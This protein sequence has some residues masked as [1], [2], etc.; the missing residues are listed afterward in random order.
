M[1][2]LSDI[3][4]LLTDNGLVDGVSDYTLRLGMMPTDPDRV[5]ALYEYPG[6][7]PEPTPSTVPQSPNNPAPTDPTT[8]VTYPTLQVRVRSPKGEYAEARAKVE[9]I[10]RY[11]HARLGV[12]VGTRSY[13]HILAQSDP[14]PLG[15]DDVGRPELTQNFT[16]VIQETI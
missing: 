15:Q 3:G 5:V 10:F 11:L 13:L 8:W 7:P 2:L 9:A 6:R 14:L 4:Q 1:A 16:T 12:V